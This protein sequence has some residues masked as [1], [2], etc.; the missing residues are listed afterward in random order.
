[1]KEY[2][3]VFIP[4]P[5]IY[6]EGGFDVFSHL[7]RGR[8]GEKNLVVIPMSFVK[9]LGE[10]DADGYSAGAKDVLMHLKGLNAVPKE[11]GTKDVGVFLAPSSDDLDIALLETE[12]SSLTLPQLEAKVSEHFRSLKEGRPTIISSDDV[13]HIRLKGTGLIVQEPQF[14]QVSAD[15]VNEGI[16][17]GNAEL[18]E[19]VHQHHH[20]GVPLETAIEIMG[21]D[22]FVNQFIKFRSGEGKDARYEY[23]RVVGDPKWN[24]NRTR[25]VDTLNEKVR[26]LSTHEYEKKMHIGDQY[27]PKIFDITPR[28]MEQYL[29][30]QHGLLNPDVSL[31]FLCGSQGSGKTLLSYVAAV[32]Q[33]LWFNKEIKDLRRWRCEGGLYDQM[34]LLKPNEVLGGSRREIGFLPGSQYEKIKPHIEPYIDA[35]KRSSLGKQ[36]PFEELMRHPK[37]END[38]GPPR[39]LAMK[40]LKIDGGAH[41]PADHEVFEVKFSGFMRGRSFE[42][43]LV[44]IDEAQNFTPYE[45]KTIIER[46]GENSKGI[47]MG[48]PAQFD[49]PHCTRE[50]NGLTHAIKHYFGKPYASLVTLSRNYRSQASEDA[51]SWRVYSG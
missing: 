12:G 47:I 22:L 13:D 11:E 14:L 44:L 17:S 28:D 9:E 37:F 51:L 38:F 27:L 2:H 20:E 6:R 10:T 34:F 7:E 35:H 41:F 42:N 21:R 33:V 8:N 29:A 3:S 46:L 31:F 50:R 49:N 43:A 23:A 40:E 18:Y 1:M 25:I 30:L 32:N 39:S 5:H 45:L 24:G 19:Q 15:I 26:L 4:L 48:D 16:I 36:F